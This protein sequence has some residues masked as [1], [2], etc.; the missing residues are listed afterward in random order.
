MLL[1]IAQIILLISII[2]NVS[3]SQEIFLCESY[4][5]DGIPVGPLN[6]IEIKPYGTA[7]YVLI[8]NEEKFS[9]PLLYMFIDKL[10]DDKYVPFDSKTLNID[11][12]KHWAV[13]NFEFKEPGSYEIYF[14][15]TSQ[16]RLATTKVKTFFAIENRNQ[17]IST[18][19]Q[20]AGDCEFVFCE[21]VI[22]GKPVNK[23]NSISLSNFGGQVFIYLNNFVP[24]GIEKII[25][26]VWKRSIE[27][28]NYEE[29]LDSKKFRILP[30]W[31]DT[32]FRYIFTQI[33]DFKIDIFDDQNNFIAS[34]T[35]TIQN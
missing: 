31:S 20:S 4:S 34:N 15:N 11:I 8:N 5:E 35:I 26:Q 19:F 24:F 32:F 16:K 3:L 7:V 2:T 23:F 17:V 9:D 21:L 27:N 14:L 30:D 10:N 18:E 6:K 12:N 1:R 13:T 25:I 22:N 28:R 29:L 33:G